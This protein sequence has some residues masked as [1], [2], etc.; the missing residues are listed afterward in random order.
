[1]TSLETTADTE[2]RAR[3]ARVIP[4]G[5]YGHQSAASLPAGFPQFIA[6]GDG[7]RIVDVDGREYIDFMCSYGPIILGHH[8]PVVDAA[9]RR[10]QA[11]GDCFNGPSPTMVELAELLVDTVA[12]AD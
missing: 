8:D 1:M 12:H 2:L 4:G 3:A 10:Q 9:A 7:C 5:M 6:R 11:D